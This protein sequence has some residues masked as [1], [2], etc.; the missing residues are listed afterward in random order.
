MPPAIGIKTEKLLYYRLYTYQ[1]GLAVATY[2]KHIKIVLLS[3]TLCFLTFEVCAKDYVP[4]TDNMA[5][6]LTKVNMRS[7]TAVNTSR[8]LAGGLLGTFVGFGIGHAIQGR[9]D[10][11]YGWVF[12]ATQIGGYATGIVF[13][14]VAVVAC[15]T[16]NSDPPF[17]L[18]NTADSV[19]DE[20]PGSE[21]A[22]KVTGTLAIAAL[23]T[24]VVSRL[25]EM[26]HVWLPYTPSARSAGKRKTAHHLADHAEPTLSVAPLLTGKQFGLQ[27][28]LRL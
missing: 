18:T 12:T 15:A 17:K 19:P 28:A 16:S 26:V 4:T 2:K 25:F 11:D 10:D 6:L 22:C 5:E 1:P 8:Y 9:W 13:G 27:L 24:G 21:T 23:L 7:N 3:T 20:S 14:I